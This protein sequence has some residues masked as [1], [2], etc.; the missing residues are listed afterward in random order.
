MN[1]RKITLLAATGIISAVLLPSIALA[2]PVT[3]KVPDSSVA[4][5]L[6]V[7]LAGLC[8]AALRQ[9]K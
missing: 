7:T 4:L 8:F 5:P 3:H 9:R 1:A 2:S 6:A